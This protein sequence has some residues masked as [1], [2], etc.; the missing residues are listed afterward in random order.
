ME[1]PSAPDITQGLVLGAIAVVMPT[2]LLVA[3][4][5]S[6]SLNF[7]WQHPLFQTF[8]FGSSA[9][10][11]LVVAFWLDGE[12]RRTAQPGVLVLAVGFFCLAA[13]LLIASR[14]R[15]PVH[16]GWFV[17]VKGSWTTLFAASAAVLIAWRRVRTPLQ[18]L[19]LQRPA[20][21]RAA[22]AGFFLLWMTGALL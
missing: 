19:I 13:L 7:Q 1:R 3:L 8:L 12:V 14:L 20:A 11:C 10:V 4:A 2:V 5:G 6:P 9:V 16:L 17:V 15:D 22:G 18:E 21:C